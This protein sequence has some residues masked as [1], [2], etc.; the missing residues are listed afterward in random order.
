MGEET[1]RKVRGQEAEVKAHHFF[2]SDRLQF[3]A[4]RRVQFLLQ[5]C[6]LHLCSRQL[7]PQYARL[8]A[9]NVII[10]LPLQGKGGDRKALTSHGTRAMFSMLT[11]MPIFPALTW[12]E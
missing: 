2:G 7:Q 11:G 9:R 12:R 8:L 3:F 10:G 4:P 5:G 1:V 6:D